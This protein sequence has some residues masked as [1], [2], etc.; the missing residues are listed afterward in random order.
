M[1]FNK[2]LLCILIMHIFGLAMVVSNMIR[3]RDNIFDNIFDNILLGVISLMLL[4][5][6]IIVLIDARWRSKGVYDDDASS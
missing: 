5:N 6:A 1:K 3:F 4:I 2:S